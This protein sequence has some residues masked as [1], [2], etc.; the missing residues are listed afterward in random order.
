MLTEKISYNKQSSNNINNLTFTSK[1]TSVSKA[2]S[3]SKPLK[4]LHNALPNIPSDISC[5]IN[6]KKYIDIPIKNIDEYNTI[7]DRVYSAKKPNGDLMWFDNERLSYYPNATKVEQGLLPY[8]GERDSSF[9]INFFLS[10]RLT[11]EKYELWKENL[12]ENK[13]SFIDMIRVLDFSLKNLDEEF[14]KYKGIVFRQGFMNENSGQFLSTTKN[15][16]IAAQLNNNYIFFSPKRGFSV[17]RT[18]NGHNICD[19]QNK[20]GVSFSTSEEEILLPRKQKYK[21]LSPSELDE[22]LDNAR[23]TFAGKI[24]WGANKVINGEIK[25][26]NG[27]DKEKLLGLVK[28]FDEV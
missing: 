4:E 10:G 7:F 3:E 22:E 24:I 15:P 17:I 12:P 9:Y 14:G 2:C 27:Y 8:C 20:M 19:F 25:E 11:P 28:V 26:V 1:I 18:N 21:E 6:H 16:S 23:K 13:A 5:I